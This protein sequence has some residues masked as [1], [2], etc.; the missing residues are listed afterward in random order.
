M[1]LVMTLPLE[2][3]FLKLYL[4]AASKWPQL[5]FHHYLVKMFRA[6]PHAKGNICCHLEALGSNFSCS[7]INY[8]SRS[9]GIA[10]NSTVLLSHEQTAGHCRASI[11]L[12]SIFTNVP[13]LHFS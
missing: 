3:W 13:V 5:T 4:M 1:H 10:V 8:I 2:V 12:H 11:A 9:A 7:S 6:H